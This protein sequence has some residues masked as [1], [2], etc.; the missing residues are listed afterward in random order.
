MIKKV[1]IVVPK[2]SSKCCSQYSRILKPITCDQLLLEFEE[3]ILLGLPN[4]FHYENVDCT[5]CA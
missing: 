3:G 4:W 2:V 1:T 5:C